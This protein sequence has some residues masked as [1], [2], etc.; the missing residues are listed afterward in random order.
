MTSELLIWTLPPS[1]V[2]LAQPM[3]SAPGESVG[4]YVT[5]LWFSVITSRHL[6]C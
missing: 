6:S 5:K 2:C 4:T 1:S 3:L